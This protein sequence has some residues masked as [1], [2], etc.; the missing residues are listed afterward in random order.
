[1]SEENVS[2][3][4]SPYAIKDSGER[5]EFESG[6]VRDT[7]DGKVLWHLVHDGPM[8]KRYAQHLTTGAVKYEAR[9]WMKADSMV[10]WERF[11][12]SAYRHFMQWYEGDVDEDHASAT[13]FN[14]NG[15]EYVAALL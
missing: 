7:A 5:A 10:E 4:K 9:N 2:G 15:R 12:E 3:V 6:M 8:L 11:S 14:I 1:M 13:W